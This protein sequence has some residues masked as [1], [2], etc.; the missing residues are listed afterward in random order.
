[1]VAPT[2]RVAL[3]LTVPVAIVVKLPPVFTFCTRTASLKAALTAASPWFSSFQVTVTAPPD[4]GLVG[5]AATEPGGDDQ[6]VVI[7]QR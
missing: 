6:V 3:P 5:V 7:P 1:M 4:I 2:A